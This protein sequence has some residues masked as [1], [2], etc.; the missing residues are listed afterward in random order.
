MKMHN[1]EVGE[2]IQ[3]LNTNVN[4]LT[5]DEVNKRLKLH[6]KNELAAA[7]KDGI[8]KRFFAQL[9]DCMIIILLISAVVS[10]IISVIDKSND[11]TEPII[12]LAIVILNAAI[13]VFQESKAERAIE[14]LKE[15]TAQ[16]STVMRNG[17][18][19][20]INSEDLTIGDIVL[21]KAGDKVPADCRIISSNS[22]TTDESALTGESQPVEKNNYKLSDKNLVVADM[23]N[24]LWCSTLVVTG[25]ATAVVTD[26]GNETQVGK[27]AQ[28]INNAKA[29][30]TSLQI[31]LAKAG[32]VMGIGALII[33]FGI[34]IVGI[35]N[36]IN[37]LEMFMT[38]VGLAV[39]AI[40][41][42]LPAIVTVMLATGVRQMAQN[43]AVV[44]KLP[45]VETLG[46][47]NVI[48][49]DKT[50]TITKNQ[51]TVQKV[52]GNRNDVFTYLLMCNNNSDSTEKAIVLA[53][54]KELIKYDTIQNMYK[55]VAERP[56]N[57]DD[58]YMV[59]VNRFGNGYK[60]VIKGAP[61]VILSKCSGDNRF[62]LEETNNMAKEGLRVIAVA[63][64]NTNSPNVNN[65]LKY[66]FC[67]LVGISDPIREEVYE[68]VKLSKIAGIKPV[69]ITGDYKNTALAIAKQAGITDKDDCLTGEELNR[70]TEEEL[71]ERVKSVSVFARVTPNHKVR[72]V[73]AYQQNG[74]VTAMTGDGVNDAPALKSAD[75]GCAMGTGTEVAKSASD[76]VL[77]DNNF[78]TIITAVKLGRII[79]QNIKKT[80]HFLLSSNIGE[81]LTIFVAVLLG[82]PTPLTAIQLLWV[83]LIT[84]SLP[85]IALGMEKDDRD[86]M[87]KPPIPKDASIF[88]GGMACNFL[89]EGMM[90]ATL[91]LIAYFI[92]NKLY[93]DL[94]I[95]RTMSFSVL[96]A[97]QLFHSFNMHSDKPIIV[98]G[99]SNNKFLIFS[100]VFCIALQLILVTVA[101][102]ANLFNISVLNNAQLLYVLMLSFAPI[103]IMEIV[104]LIDNIF[105]K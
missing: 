66:N 19:E 56:F 23:K 82:M 7:K 4:G 72:I 15:I 1:L 29:P 86:I 105:N 97:S 36:K 55:K 96:A 50:G 25:N 69:L 28:M 11:I 102:V 2:V 94:S 63:Q 57:S 68:A 16:K 34:F 84:D 81:I 33:C 21:L 101:P 8:L 70:L 6:G 103:V 88:S 14:A 90:I 65:N 12:I 51:M 95:A 75:I 64:I 98:S 104:K 17:K 20:I 18:T 62:V 58:K 39:A 3:N 22:V 79:Y 80:I 83:N 41:E 91:S 46:S 47:A 30:M 9:N 37:Y 52:Y 67:G 31:K 32:K 89:L 54:E 49:S 74:M 53:G 92:G 44:R 42:G 93:C 60:Q 40:P 61:D 38:S 13:G 45:A 73:N 27:I 99:I 77:L 43:N 78:A 35:I 5:Y 76:I 59:T 24:M 48:C 71:K 85:A 10:Y 26:I 100:F 87:S